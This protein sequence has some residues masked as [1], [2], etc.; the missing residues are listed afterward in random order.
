MNSLTIIYSASLK[1]ANFSAGPAVF[2]YCRT[3]CPVAC[4][5]KAQTLPVFVYIP[6]I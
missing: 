2:A 5:A 4:Q 1:I 3:S 6:V